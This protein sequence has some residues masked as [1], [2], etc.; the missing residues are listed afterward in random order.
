M[1]VTGRKP[2]PYL[3]AVRE[4]NPGQRKL[5][6]G[7]VFSGQLAEPDWLELLPGPASASRITGAPDLDDDDN[8]FD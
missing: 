2:K 4:G 7:A 5:S 8:P 1:A 3:Q 6:R